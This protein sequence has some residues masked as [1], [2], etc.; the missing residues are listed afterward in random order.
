MSFRKG[1]VD[2]VSIKAASVKAGGR[3][4]IMVAAFCVLAMLKLVLGNAFRM[5]AVL[6]LQHSDSSSKGVLHILRDRVRQ[7]RGT[8]VRVLI[9]VVIKLVRSRLLLHFRLKDSDSQ[10]SVPKIQQR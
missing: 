10:G 1:V 7:I 3:S 2:S 5:N 4:D 9:L 6:Q 8:S